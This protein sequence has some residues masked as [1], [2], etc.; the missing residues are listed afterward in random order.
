MG[1]GAGEMDGSSLISIGS[2]AAQ[3]V[4]FGLGVYAIIIR[5]EANLK[6]VKSDMKE[7]KD[8]AK[9]EISEIK[10]FMKEIKDTVTKVAVQDV[11]LDNMDRRMNSVD[12]QIDDLR[13]GRGYIRETLDG[14]YPAG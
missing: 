4:I 7:M 10:D 6:S 9:E 3:T 5:N 8:S 2:M 14:E 11:R 12:R 13:R 1:L